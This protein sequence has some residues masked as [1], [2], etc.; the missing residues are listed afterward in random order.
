MTPHDKTHRSAQALS[1]KNIYIYI[2][3]DTKQ[4][5]TRERNDRERERTDGDVREIGILNSSK[6]EMF[7]I[8]HIYNGKESSP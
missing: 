5:A 7:Y 3:I 8:S 6:S 4:I 2:C 1:L